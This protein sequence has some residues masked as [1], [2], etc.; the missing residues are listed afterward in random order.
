MKVANPKKDPKFNA[1][2]FCKLISDIKP[3]KKKKKRVK[4]NK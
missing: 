2:K 3:K 1:V 4:K